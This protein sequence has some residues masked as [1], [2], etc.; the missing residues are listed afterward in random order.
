MFILAFHND[1][2]INISSVTSWFVMFIWAFCSDAAIPISSASDKD[3]SSR[4]DIAASFQVIK[5]ICVL[6]L[7]FL[8]KTFFSILLYIFA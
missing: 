8:Y 4:A 6:S 2:A 1:A 3:R 7:S 5:C